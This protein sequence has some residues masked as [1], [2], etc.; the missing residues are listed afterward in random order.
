MA[1]RI[2]KLVTELENKNAEIGVLNGELNYLR[3]VDDFKKKDQDFAN[4]L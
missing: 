2:D 1:K 4:L 3:S